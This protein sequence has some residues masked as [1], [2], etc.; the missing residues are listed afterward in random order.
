MGLEQLTFD[1]RSPILVVSGVDETN[2][3]HTQGDEWRGGLGMM[4]E[5][6]CRVGVR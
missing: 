1:T 6:D 5:E 2:N 4:V 3:D